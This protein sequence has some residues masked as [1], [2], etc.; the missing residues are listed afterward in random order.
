VLILGSAV[1]VMEYGTKGSVVEINS[2]ATVPGISIVELKRQ[3]DI[4]LLIL[5]YH[6]L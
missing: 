2:S 6:A 5:I 1:V 3:F 4:V